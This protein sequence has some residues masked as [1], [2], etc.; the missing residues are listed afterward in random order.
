MVTGVRPLSCGF[1]EAMGES[2]TV[3]SWNDRGVWRGGWV[4]TGLLAGLWMVLVAG[5]SNAE[6]PSAGWLQED[7]PSLAYI[8]PESDTITVIQ[9]SK[10]FGSEA[11]RGLIREDRETV[12][13]GMKAMLDSFFEMAGVEATEIELMV[14]AQ[15]F[16]TGEAEQRAINVMLIRTL[17]PNEVG[18]EMVT[19]RVKNE[20]RVGNEVIFEMEQAVTGNRFACIVG[21]RTIL[22]SRDRESLERS[23]AVGKSG[24]E[25]ATWYPAWKEYLGPRALSM[26]L[27]SAQMGPALPAP[28]RG[29]GEASM[30]GLAADLDDRV[31]VRGVAL[32]DSVPQAIEMVKTGEAGLELARAALERLESV[33][34]QD[35]AMEEPRAIGER[36]IAAAKISRRGSLAMVDSTFPIEWG[37]L[38][39]MFRTTRSAAQRTQSM[40]NIRQIVLAMHNYHSVTGRMPPAVL[41]HQSG[42]KYSW[43]IAILPYLEQSQIYDRYNFEEPWN[44]EHNRAVTA[45][46]PAVFRAGDM[47][48][49]TTNSAYFMLIG[50]GMVGSAEGGLDFADARDGSSNTVMVVESRQSIHWAEPRDLSGDERKFGEFGG[51]FDGGFNAGFLDGHVQF[52]SDRTTPRTLKGMLTYDG[53]EVIDP[54]DGD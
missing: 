2:G 28:L 16:P 43:R 22:W 50:P 35:P 40:N 24:P 52:L 25:S 10:I 26:I 45:R 34:A 11:Y 54:G 31:S 14:Q 37:K 20:F 15:S 3:K 5:A 29:L 36:A 39:P 12:E 30:L 23:L 8:P 21:D 27:P 18:F 13:S 48:A 51:F 47:P 4:W 38:L 33:A 44:S 17:R 49:D 32:C 41:T 42:Q 6:P 19:Q 46:M 1:S 9:L 7:P 53:G